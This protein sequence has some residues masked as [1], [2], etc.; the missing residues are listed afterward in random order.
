MSIRLGDFGIDLTVTLEGAGSID[1][2]LTKSILLT[3]PLGVTTAYVAEFVTDGTDSKI[4][5]ITLDGDIDLKGIWYIK[6]NITYASA[7][8]TSER[9]GFLVE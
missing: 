1:N 8:Y 7:S 4:K 9:E 3:S 6:G 5:Y 2:V